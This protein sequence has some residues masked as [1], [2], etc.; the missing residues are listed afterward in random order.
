ELYREFIDRLVS[1]EE[2]TTI[3]NIV[4][5]TIKTNFR[6]KIHVIFDKV[7]LEDG[8]V[9]E[10]CIERVSWGLLNS[11]ETPSEDRR[12]EELPDAQLN[13][14]NLQAHVE[15][16][17]N[18]HKVPLHL[19]VFK[20]M[21]QHVL[22]ATRVLGRVSGHMMLVGVGGSGRRSLTRLAAHICGYKL[23][24]P[25]INSANNYQDLKTDLKKLVIS[26]GIEEKA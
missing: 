2:V 22:R 9:T 17:N 12:Y 5:S 3:Y 7:A 10:A 20:Y 1:P 21:S 8:S 16:Y 18:T 23:V 24:A 19:V 14:Q 26:A 6:D 25:I 11:A 13:Y 4:V 15:D